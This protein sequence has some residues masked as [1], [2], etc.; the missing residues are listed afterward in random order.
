MPDKDVEIRDKFMKLEQKVE[1]LEKTNTQCHFDIIR[2]QEKT[3]TKVDSLID[4]LNN[5]LDNKAD[6]KDLQRLDN[7][8]WWLIGLSV[9]AFLGLVV[10]AIQAFLGKV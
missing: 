10:T 4:K 1:D 6:V 8:L 2:G 7:R 5:A 3:A 9:V